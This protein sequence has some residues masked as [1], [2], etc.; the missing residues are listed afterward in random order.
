MKGQT[1]YG[2]KQ[3][4]LDKTFQDCIYLSDFIEANPIVYMA[5]TLS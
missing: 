3:I 1:D 2:V 4:T 5:F